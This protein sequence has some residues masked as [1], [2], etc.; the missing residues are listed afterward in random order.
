[1]DPL[2]LAARYGRFVLIGG[3][4]VGLA[5]PGLAAALRPLVPQ[6]VAVLLF[7]AA[8]RMGPSVFS[9]ALRGLGGTVVAVVALQVAL[10][11]AVVALGIAT[12]T[13]QTPALLALAVMA[14]AP[15]I[16]GAPNICLM[17]GVSGAPA[18]RLLILGTALVPLT[19]LPV[20]WL[21]PALGDVRVVLLSALRLLGVI[22]VAGGA[23]FALRGLLWRRPGPAAVVRLDGAS[24]LALAIFVV[25]LMPALRAVLI[26]DP[27]RA[28]AWLALACAANFGLQIAARALTISRPEG[29]SVALVAGNRNMALFLVALPEEV[30]APLMVFIACYQVPMYL[31]PLV[32]GRLYRGGARA[33][34]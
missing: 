12:G 32:M 5:L 15:S 27:W 8:L 3:L 17:M 4:V 30:V 22:V 7:L 28:A 2:T 29:A 11:L 16:S 19:V 1:M 33:G 10:P 21:L 6:M 25:G 23:G 14:A 31:T 34:A 18:M 20:F 26:S 13:A 9:G 24:A